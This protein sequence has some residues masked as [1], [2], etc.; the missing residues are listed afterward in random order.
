VEEQRVDEKAEEKK[1]VKILSIDGGGIRGVIPAMILQ[2]IEEM[3]GRPI[4]KL[5]DLISGTSTGGVMALL[6]TKPKPGS[7]GEPMYSPKEIVELYVEHGKEMFNRSLLYKIL[8]INGWRRPKYPE[9]SVLATLQGYLDRS[10]RAQLKDALTD[11][12]ITSYDIQQRHPFFF[13]KCDAEEKPYLNFYMSDAARGTSAAPTFFPTVKIKSV[14]GSA[15][16]YLIDG[17]LVA[18]NPSNLA[19]AE[20]ISHHGKYTYPFVVS[21]GTGSYEAPLHYRSARR[22]G[23]FGWAPRILDV[24]FDGVS[25][26]VDTVCE[27]VVPALSPPD[28]YYRFQVPLSKGD[29]AMDN[30]DPDNIEVLQALTLK[31]MDERE[32]DLERLAKALME[33]SPWANAER[34][35]DRSFKRF[36]KTLEPGMGA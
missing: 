1:T 25:G 32:E 17:G 22:W 19:I 24:M 12:L 30:Y 7:E 10:E 14:D 33:P 18:N 8:S 11:V 15:S 2:R 9:Q 35:R 5:F 27:E 21:L 34:S 13:K 4:V 28:Y 23:F 16:Y 3:A 26:A 31:M 36:T 20:A 29:D 6:L